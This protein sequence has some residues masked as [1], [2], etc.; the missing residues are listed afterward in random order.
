MNKDRLKSILTDIRFWIIFLFLLRLVGIT[1]APLEV[2]HNWR[3]AMTNMVARN[4][5]D[6]GAHM[7]YPTI[8]MAGEKTGIIGAEFP[9]LNY[10]IYLISSHT[11]LIIPTGMG[12]SST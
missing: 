1:N 10:L 3:Q 9:L 7:L 5:V 8:D 2:G 11:R 4:F 6:H 12:E